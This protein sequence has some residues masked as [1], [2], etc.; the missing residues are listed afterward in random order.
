MEHAGSLFVWEQTGEGETGVIVDGDVEGLDTGAWVAMGAVACGADPG[1]S[2][3]SELLDVE[4][5]KIAWSIAFVAEGWRFWRFQGREAVEVAA[6]Q[7]A[8]KSGLGD[9]QHHQ[10]L[11]VRAALA[12]QGEDRGFESGSRL[13]GL[14]MRDGG[15][16]GE[17]GRKAC[18]LSALQPSADG[19][20]AD[21]ES[22]GCG[23]ARQVLR[24]ESSDHFSSHERGES[25]I[26]VHV[27]RAEWLEVEYSSTTSLPYLPRADNLL[28]HD[29]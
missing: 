4:V 28:K 23:A 8:G 20:L 14:M 11:G 29:S 17:A 12:A 7:D 19:L 1:F 13:A 25:G 21:G 15:M 3:A 22:G 27:V 9:R 18:F 10:D 16:I 26:S 6:A 24:G 5:E 2:E